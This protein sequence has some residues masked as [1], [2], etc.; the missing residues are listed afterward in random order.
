M[1]DVLMEEC[2]RYFRERSVY[3]KVFAKFRKKYESLNHMG[4]S[5]VLTNLTEEEKEQLGGFVGQDFFGKKRISLSYQTIE[6]ALQRSRFSAFDFQTIL[7]TYYQNRLV[8][9]KEQK[10]QEELKRQKGFERLL[11]KAKNDS[12][13]EWLRE[14][15]KAKNKDYKYLCNMLGEDE[16]NCVLM[17][18]Q[19]FAAGAQLPAETG[20]YEL[21]PVF[22]TRITKEPHFFDIGKPAQ[23]LLT[24]YLKYLFKNQIEAVGSGIE[25]VWELLYLAGILKDDLSNIVLA[26]GLHG[27]R[28]DGSLHQGMEGFGKEKEPV[29]LTLQSLTGLQSVFSEKKVIYMVE[30]PAVFSYLCKKYPLEAFI[31]GNGQLRL[32]VWVLFGKLD[33]CEKIYYAGDFDPEGIGIAERL[34]KRFP[35]QVHLW[36]YEVELYQ[37]YCSTHC[38]SD[39]SMKKLEKITSP[40]LQELCEEIKKRGYAAY[41][42]AMLGEYKVE[43]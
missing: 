22:A 20:E 29:Q 35:E 7:E 38:I 15:Q 14:C 1:N 3:D 41:Q 21:L 24:A 25:Q 39:A 28:W 11:K 4:G 31:C 9:R 27:K 16:Q 32:A 43:V 19:V 6:K 17:M 18:E 2:Q 12:E 26:Y 5:I 33:Y 23:H 8:G 10:K 37:K 40:E 30:N 42:E 36:C 13:S 34:K